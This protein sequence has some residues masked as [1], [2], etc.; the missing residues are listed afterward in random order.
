MFELDAIHDL[1]LPAAGSKTGRALASMS[2][3]RTFE[4]CKTLDPDHYS[5]DARD[6]V[7]ALRAA[8]AARLPGDPHTIAHAI[9]DPSI[10]VPIRCGL[11]DPSRLI[12][13]IDRLLVRLGDRDGS[14]D[15]D[16]TTVFGKVVVRRGD[17]FLEQCVGARP[18]G[19]VDLASFRTA[20]DRARREVPGTYEDLERFG[21]VFLVTD[22]EA[23][24][25]TSIGIGIAAPSTEADE[26]FGAIVGS[27]VRGKIFALVEGRPHDPSALG[28]LVRIATQLAIARASDHPVDLAEPPELRP[29]DPLSWVAAEV[30]RVVSSR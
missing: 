6:A 25:P 26:L 16:T 13:A 19:A 10:G 12:P 30:R 18:S 21:S 11:A 9:A 28:S 7:I 2:L 27:I 3:R 24:E 14:I 23:I 29:D 20:L 1:V 15:A 22:V 5:A 17:R 8:F 4:R